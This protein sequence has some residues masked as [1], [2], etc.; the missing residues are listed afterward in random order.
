MGVLVLQ[1]KYA[2]A[3]STIGELSHEG[4][5]L[6]FILEDV[7][8]PTKIKGKTAIPAGRYQI[9]ITPSPRFKRDLPLLL[10]VPN[11]VGIR[12]HPGNDAGDTEGCLLP[13][14]I[15]ETD[16]VLNSRAA[17]EKLFSTIRFLLSKGDCWI[18]I[19]DVLSGE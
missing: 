9:Q 2:T 11:Y 13:G 5:F 6:C 10:N 18:E 17:F 14:L 8:R 4:R 16:R 15:M 12:I 3:N 7:V 19:K 1:R